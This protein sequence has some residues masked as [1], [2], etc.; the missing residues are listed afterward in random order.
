[1]SNETA[2]GKDLKSMMHFMA[3]VE[4]EPA[5]N[6]WE[7]TDLYNTIIRIANGR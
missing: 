7:P 3:I 1:M 2:K 5:I 4:T 6:N